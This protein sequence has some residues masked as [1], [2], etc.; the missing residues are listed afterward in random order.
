M[1]L[2]VHDY[3]GWKNVPNSFPQLGRKTRA[4]NLINVFETLTLEVTNQ[5]MAF[6]WISSTGYKYMYTLDKSKQRES[7]KRGDIG[8]KQSSLKRKQLSIC[9]VK[10]DAGFLGP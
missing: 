2:G 10:S 1:C 9:T 7:I 6:T 3:Q 5:G 4:L 8:G